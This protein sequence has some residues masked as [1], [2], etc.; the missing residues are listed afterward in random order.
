MAIIIVLTLIASSIYAG[1][2]DMNT[3]IE[4]NKSVVQVSESGSSITA[5]DVF[6]AVA[7][8]VVIAGAIVTAIVISPIW[9]INKITE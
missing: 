9:L 3:S 4:S 7:T 5:K 6:V 1:E 2:V 8:P